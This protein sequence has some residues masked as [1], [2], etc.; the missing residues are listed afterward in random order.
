MKMGG[1]FHGN[2]KSI[3]FGKKEKYIQNKFCL[4]EYKKFVKNILQVEVLQK[5][6]LWIPVMEGAG[7]TRAGGAG[8]YRS[9][10]K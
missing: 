8:A 2:K 3:T 10:N 9:L 4:L 5:I 1:K 7:G 6:L